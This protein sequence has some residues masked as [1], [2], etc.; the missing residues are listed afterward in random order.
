MHRFREPGTSAARRPPSALTVCIL[1]IVLVLILAA[2]VYA[3]GEFQAHRTLSAILGAAEP[4]APGTE[5]DGP[6]PVA[7]VASS[8]Y[9]TLQPFQVKEVEAVLKKHFTDPRHIIDATAHIGGDTTNF[10]RV[11]PK[12]TVTAIEIKGDTYAALVKNARAAE[13][14][15]GRPEGTIRAVHANCVTFL[16]TTSEKAD[17]VYL[18][19]PWGGPKYRELKKMDLYLTDAKG[20]RWDTADIVN[21]ILQRGIAPCVVLKAPFNFRTGRFSSRVD[22]PIAVHPIGQSSSRQSGVSYYLIVAGREMM[23]GEY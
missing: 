18:D 15:L 6:E 13:K 16:Q 23:K 14:R 2:V 8:K 3:V 9:S 7:T 22:V 4:A 11:F 19:P 21:L 5:D 10:M 17:F 12:A 20:K 1:V